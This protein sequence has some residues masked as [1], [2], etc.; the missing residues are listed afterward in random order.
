MSYENSMITK[1]L[2]IFLLLSL[3]PYIRRPTVLPLG[4]T[5]YIHDYARLTN[6]IVQT[7][8]ACLHNCQ[9]YL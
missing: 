4:I 3:I 7:N 5:F 8:I 2:Y 1:V 6:G 9:A